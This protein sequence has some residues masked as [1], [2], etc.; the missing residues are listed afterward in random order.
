MPQPTLPN[1]E[2]AILGR[3]VESATTLS[4]DAAQAILA[5]GFT[6]A[7]KE[8]MRKLLAKAKD[9]TQTAEE[10]AEI[11]CYERVGHLLNIMKS[12]A[13]RSLKTRVQPRKKA[14]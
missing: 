3:V 10:E 1:D 2:F 6:E 11:A 9:G 12:V 8:R 7:D 4:A 13:R 5:F 14:Q